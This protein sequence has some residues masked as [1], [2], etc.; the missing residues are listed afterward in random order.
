[1]TKFYS[2][3]SSCIYIG[4]KVLC[5]RRHWLLECHANG[6]LQQTPAEILCGILQDPVHAQFPVSSLLWHSHHP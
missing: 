6:I 2:V 3:Y 4:D 1:M 5:L